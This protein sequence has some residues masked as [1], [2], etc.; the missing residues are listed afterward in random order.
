MG[1]LGDKIR[2]WKKKKEE[3]AEFQKLV[4][5][6]TLPLRRQAYLEAK[7]KLALQEGVELAKKTTIVKKEPTRESFGLQKDFQLPKSFDNMLKPTESWNIPGQ[8]SKHHI[9]LLSINLKIRVSFLFVKVL[10]LVQVYQVV[11]LL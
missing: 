4:E 8:Q 3:Q 6:E 10:L 5:A 1:F 9:N 7:K 2:D 11:Q